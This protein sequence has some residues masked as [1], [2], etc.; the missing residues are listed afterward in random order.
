M[1]LADCYGANPRLL[2]LSREEEARAVP[3]TIKRV[4]EGHYLQW[5]NACIAGYGNAETSSDFSYA[6]PF[7]ESILIA[8]LAIRSHGLKNPNAKGAEDRYPG[9]QRLLWDTENM[10]VTNFEAAN[11]FVKRQYRMPWSLNFG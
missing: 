4:T 7:V 8:N 1:L 2:P 3:E 9:R 5:V 10:R 11:Q 6:G